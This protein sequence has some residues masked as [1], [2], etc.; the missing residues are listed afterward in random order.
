MEENELYC[1]R[2]SCRFEK[3]KV[4]FTYLGHTFFSDAPCCPMCGQ[5]YLSEELV[6]GRVVEVERQLEDK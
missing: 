5:V 4:Y 1:A 3:K 2:C 6:R